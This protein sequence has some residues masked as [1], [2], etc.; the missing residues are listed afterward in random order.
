MIA[1]LQAEP[2]GDVTRDLLAD[3]SLTCYA[4]AVNV[5]EVYYHVLRADSEATAE[6]A[7]ELL[8]LDGLIIREDMDTEFWKSVGRLKARGRLALADCVCI[9]LAQRLGGEVV[10]S[11]HH[12]FDA[13]VPLGLCPIRFI[14]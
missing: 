10:T 12:E 9:A 13:L 3:T 5:A 8:L 4:H 1:Y 11:D 14:R 2:G 6:L 7:V